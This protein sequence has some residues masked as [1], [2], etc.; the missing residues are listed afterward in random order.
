M[1]LIQIAF[2]GTLATLSLAAYAQDMPGMKMDDMNMNGMPMKQEAR[3][4]RQAT[5]EGTIKAIDTAKQRVTIAHGAV[6]AVQWPPMTMAFAATAQQ[7]QGLAIGDRV[8][9][10]FH[11]EGGAATIVSIRK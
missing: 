8:T 9:F 4:A 6:P 1:K 7:L 11:L 2:T 5:A 10:V 3:Q